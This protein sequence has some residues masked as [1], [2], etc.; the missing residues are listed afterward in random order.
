MSLS[1]LCYEVLLGL[2]GYSRTGH[3]GMKRRDGVHLVVLSARAGYRI[4]T[5]VTFVKGQIAPDG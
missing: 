5:P 2:G 3:D 1:Q 4:V